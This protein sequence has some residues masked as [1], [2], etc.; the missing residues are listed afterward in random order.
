MESEGNYGDFALSKLAQ[1]FNKVKETLNSLSQDSEEGEK[2]LR[3]DTEEIQINRFDG[4]Y[5]SRKQ[6][7]KRHKDSYEKDP[8]NL[9][10]DEERRKITMVI[11]LNEDINDQDTT[12]QGSLRLFYPDSSTDVD[13]VPRMGR[14]VLFKSET[15]MHEVLPTLGFD[16]YAITVWF[17]Q[18]TKKNVPPPIPIPEDYTIFVSIASYRDP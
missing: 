14:A 3:I 18:V 7:F 15:L 6:F 11:F 4:L 12:A 2:S 5:D 17:T 1:T 10:Q 13:I 8:N 16:N 9:D